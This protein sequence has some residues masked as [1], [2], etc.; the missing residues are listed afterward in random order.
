MS[1]AFASASAAPAVRTA[2]ASRRAGGVGVRDGWVVADGVERLGARS[3]AERRLTGPGGRILP[4]GEVLIPGAHNTSN[5]L[6]A[7]TVGLLFGVAPDA[8]RRRRCR[9]SAAS[10]IASSWWP[11]STA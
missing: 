2:A 1:R 9:R 10:S 3:V 11:R 5:V 7:V 4:L 8:I 6:A